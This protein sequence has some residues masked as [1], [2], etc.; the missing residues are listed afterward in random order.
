MSRTMALIGLLGITLLPLA[1]QEQEQRRSCW[2]RDFASPDS[3]KVYAVC[4]QGTVWFTKDGG[5][6]WEQRET[7][8]ENNL[9]AI[10][11]LDANRGLVIGRGGTVLATDDG[12][13]TWV[14]RDSKTTENLMELSFVGDE[15]WVSGYAGKVLHTTDGGKTWEDQKTGTRQTLETIYFHDTKHGWAAGWA[16]T[17][18]RTEDGGVTWNTMKAEKATWSVSAVYFKDPQN[19]W[20]VGFAGQ[21]LRSKDGGLTWDTQKSPVTDVLSSVNFEKGGRGWITYDK[22]FLTSDDGGETWKDNKTA[23]RYFL[24]RTTEVGN[25]LWALG[26]SVMLRHVGNEWKKVDSLIVDKTITFTSQPIAPVG[27]AGTK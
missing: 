22:G 14:K 17:I 25:T 23:S 7:K 12:G 26:Q 4:A 3:S 9:R 2:L 16:G 21:I 10:T 24:C 19:G 6:K 15:G 11:F 1:A 20:L 13:Q 8:A 18:L 27:P 5:N